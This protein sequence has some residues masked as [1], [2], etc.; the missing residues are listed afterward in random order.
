NM[1][2]VILVEHDWAARW[3]DDLPAGV[4]TVLALENLSWQYY[5]RRGKRLEARRFK[6]FD[7][8][9]LPRYDVLLTMSD[10]DKAHVA[11]RTETIPNGVDTTALK[12]TPL[13]TEPTALFTGT[14]DYPPNAEALDWLIKDIWPRIRA[15]LP[16]ARLFV[17]GRGAQVDG[18]GIEV[19][20]WVPEMQPWFDR[21]RAV[22]VPIR[23]GAGTRLKVLDG[24]ASGR[25]LVSTTMGAEGIRVV[26]EQHALL[27]DTADAFAAAA[28]RVLAQASVAERLGAEGRRLAEETYDWRVIGARLEAVLKDLS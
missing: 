6:R 10:D 7:D 2:D 4:P 26:P 18:P 15:E 28:V 9:H 1:P 19:A 23:S 27:A 21:A 5:E 16:E 14:F 8:T 24:L 25:G 20:G 12:A 22:L 17:V 11:G 3:Y 13:P